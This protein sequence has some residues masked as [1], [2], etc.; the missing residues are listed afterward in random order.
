MPAHG[1]Q[2]TAA[3]QSY[4]AEFAVVGLGLVLG[5]PLLGAL[6]TLASWRIAC[7]PSPRALRREVAGRH[8]LV[9]GGSKGL[10][11]ALAERLVQAGASV[12]LMAR[13]REALAETHAHLVHLA[14]EG[15]AKGNSSSKSSPAQTITQ[16][17][18]DATDYAA[19]VRA[20][21]PV[22]QEL[23][24]PVWVIA[25]T[26][27]STPG[28]LAAQPHRQGQGQG[29]GGGVAEEMM[30][31][32]YF[33]A[34]HLVRAL[35]ELGR[36]EPRADD[37][38]AKT[39]SA[40]PIQQAMPRRVIFVGSVLSTMSFLGYS[41]YAASKYA[42]RGLADSLRSEFA[43]LGVRVHLYLPANMD[44]PGFRVEES[45]KPEITGQIE[46]T[47]SMASAG[48]CA[49]VLLAGVLWGRYYITNDVLGE[50]IRIS[51]HGA[52]PRPNLLA[53]VGWVLF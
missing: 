24:M 9:S 28:F 19:V 53:E 42:V 1:L 26:G 4:G 37:T 47:A 48:T 46:G 50:M 20:L 23:G 52:S 16:L 11:R 22:V 43:P 40:I 39:I 12:T 8:V 6:Y 27:A 36:G 10:G 31:A 45:T 15:K 17:S 25:N 49:D 7:L 34:V 30:G 33:S 32:N 21:R 14:E 18:V 5:L 13:G 38:P 29:Q 51:V 3:F 35:L 2:F 41:A 44:T